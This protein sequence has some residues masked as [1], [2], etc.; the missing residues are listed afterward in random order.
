MSENQPI[1]RTRG[2]KGR[3]GVT[4]A[5]GQQLGCGRSTK[6]QCGMR[7]Q[8]PNQQTTWDLRGPLLL[9]E[10]PWKA[11]LRGR[12]TLAAFFL[13][14]PNSSPPPM[15][16]PSGKRMGKGAWEIEFSREGQRITWRAKRQVTGTHFETC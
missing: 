10:T 5:A 4:R 1:P 9:L 12:N 15:V 3:G 13:H 7:R 14:L 11:G 8:R 2:T 16:K 6:E